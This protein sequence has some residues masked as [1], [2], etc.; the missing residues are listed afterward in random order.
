MIDKIYTETTEWF[1]KGDDKICEKKAE[2]MD[3]AKSIVGGYYGEYKNLATFVFDADKGRFS[4]ICYSKDEYDSIK[5]N[6]NER[7]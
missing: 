3:E 7:Y 5:S 2:N 4:Y 6:F 1:K